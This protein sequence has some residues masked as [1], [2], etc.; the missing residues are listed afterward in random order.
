VAAS[1]DG[2]YSVILR[3]RQ[4]CFQHLQWCRR[5]INLNDL[6][7]C[8]LENV[9][10]STFAVLPSQRKGKLHSTDSDDLI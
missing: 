9:L 3:G 6:W 2:I 10:G 4:A 7:D 1:P 5:G 8:E